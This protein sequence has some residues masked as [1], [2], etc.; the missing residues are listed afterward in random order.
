MNGISFKKIEEY[1]ITPSGVMLF[2]SFIIK[3]HPINNNPVIA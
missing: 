2:K 1:N 3:R